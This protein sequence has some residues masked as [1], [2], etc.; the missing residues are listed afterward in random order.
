MY[1]TGFPE[2]GVKKEKLQ[3]FFSQFGEIQECIFARRY[4][5]HLFS[6]K[7]LAEIN[8]KY[9]HEE[10]KN[11]K[12]GLQQKNK[13]DVKREKMIS[14]MKNSLR[15][16]FEKHKIKSYEDFP[17]AGAYIVFNNLRAKVGCHNKF[18]SL[19]KVNYWKQL[20]NFICRKKQNKVIPQKYLFNETILLKVADA[21]EPVNI[22][23]EN[24]DVSPLES[25]LR[26]SF[27]IIIMALILAVSF[28]LLFYT[29]ALS[30]EGNLTCPKIKFDSK[31]DVTKEDVAAINDEDSLETEC[32]CQWMGYGNII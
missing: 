16:Y 28:V 26:K 20:F 10:W 29:S 3:Q 5:N 2:H 19:N 13:F 7:Q 22:K 6:F 11:K 27:L 17:T 25:F 9:R 12:K 15:E 14:K 21:E 4:E 32:F 30:K 31:K 8:L 18:Q 1:V 23:Y 24:L